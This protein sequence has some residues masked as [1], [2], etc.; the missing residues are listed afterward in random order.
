MSDLSQHLEGLTE[1]QGELL[2]AM[3]NIVEAQKADGADRDALKAQLDGL[4]GEMATITAEREQ[5]ARDLE[6]EQ[7]KADV[8]ALRVEFEKRAKTSGS[9]SKASMVGFD[10]GDGEKAADLANEFFYHLARARSSDHEEQ[11]AGKAALRE[12][13]SEFQA[14][15]KA[16]LGDTAAA[17]GNI[18]PNA[19]LSDVIEIATA[20]NPYRNLLTV[21]P[22]GFVTGVAIP[23]ESGVITRAA[24]AAPGATKANTAFTT[25]QYTATMYTL[26]RIYDVGN[27][28]LRNSRGAAE[29][30]VRDAI[31]R[32]FA[33]GEAY[34]ILQGSGTSEPTGLLTAI[35]TSGTFVTSFTPS[36][37]TLAGSS[38]AAIAKATGVLANRARQP[39]G[40][41]VNSSD[42]W[43]MMAQGTD[44]AGFF[45]SP[46]GGPSAI[47][48]T[49]GQARVFGLPVYADPNMPTDSMVVGEWKSAQ[50]FTGD[51]FRVDVSTEAGTR[52]D[53]NETGFRG[54]EEI[55]FNATPYVV[56]GMFQRV[57]DFTP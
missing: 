37:T 31:A 50:L 25:A 6:L 34:Y 42:F 5:K 15:T 51:A 54:E 45:F 41:V 17:G 33:L 49:Q 43:V 13:N 48:P 19:V 55:G 11:T 35:G 9:G 16:T 40:V 57:T 20:T 14:N 46:T 32:S 4:K 38:A 24:I 52:W 29:R 8:A 18:V 10:R 27:Q 12:M 22:A 36:A 56:A 23:N 28:L 39:D 26:A 2:K 53:T 3:E 30:L 44:S 7:Q 1:R 21:V 47:N